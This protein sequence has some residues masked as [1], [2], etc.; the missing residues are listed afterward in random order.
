MKKCLLLIIAFAPVTLWAAEPADTIITKANKK[1]IVEDT[2]GV[3]KVKVLKTDGTEE[4]MTFEGHYSDKQD[5]E[6]YF[7][8]PFIPTRNNSGNKRFY[9]SYPAF[10]I[11]YSGLGK[12]CFGS[13]VNQVPCVRGSK[14]WEW[15]VTL[16]TFSVP[17]TQDELQWGLTAAVQIKNVYN[18][19]SGNHILTTDKKGNT[20]LRVNGEDIKKSYISYWALKIPVMIGWCMYPEQLYCSL[21]LSLEMRDFEHSRYKIGNHTYTETKNINLNPVG[22]NIEAYFGYHN[23]MIYSSVALTPLL[24][25]KCAPKYYPITTGIAF[26]F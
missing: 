23:F 16:S 2:A 12:S 22:I 1:V 10:F 26:K 15:G 5:S 18:H 7:F 11:G 14:S 25:T 21:G 19:F 24:N 20:F 6:Q 13:L 8:S 3:T 9:A 4:K 17:L